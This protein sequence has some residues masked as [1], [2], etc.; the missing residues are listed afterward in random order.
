MFWW[1]LGVFLWL[2]CSVLS[3]GMLLA[4]LQKEYPELAA[5]D[6]HTDR[7][8]CRKFSVLGPL[9]LLKLLISWYT[10]A[11]CWRGLKF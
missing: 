5:E 4:C 8:F 2:A 10:G 3:Y 7:I 6:L 11:W 9:S 1:I